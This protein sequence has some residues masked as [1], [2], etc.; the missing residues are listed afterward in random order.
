MISRRGVLYAA[1]LSLL[2]VDLPC[3][4]AGSADT[5]KG[6]EVKWSAPHGQRNDR[7][8]QTTSLRLKWKPTAGVK[9]ERFQADGNATAAEPALSTPQVSR[10]MHS[11]VDEAD[12][13]REIELTSFNEPA[14]DPALDPFQDEVFDDEDELG[15]EDG[16]TEEQEPRQFDA[17]EVAQRTVDDDLPELPDDLRMHMRDLDAQAPVLGGEFAQAGP[18]EPERCPSPRD[19][20]PINQI[21]NRIAAEPGLFPQECALSDY[22]FQ[23]RNWAPVT[24]TWKASALCHKPL[25]FQQPKLE[26]YGHTFGLLTPIISVGHFFVMVPC[27]P[28]NMGLEPPWECVYPLGWYRPGDCA[29]YTLGPLPLSLRGA[30]SQGLITTGLWFLFP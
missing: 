3:A 30:A 21:S 18:S 10:A 5:R 19:L 13:A 25:Y 15:E 1:V 26:R 2:A 7:S 12:G 23:P 8:Q 27:L 28:Y 14:D 29:P 22:P 16:V 6:D 4:V 20:K 11:E 9:T 17:D 24:F